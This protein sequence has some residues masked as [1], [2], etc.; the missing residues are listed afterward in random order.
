MKKKGSSIIATPVMISISVIAL[1]MLFTVIVNLIMPFSIYQKIDNIAIKYMF[2]V[3]KF[4][5]LTEEEKNNLL[6]DLDLE[7]IN[8]NYVTLEYP[9]KKEPYGNLVTLKI[10]Y[11]YNYSITNF[12]ISNKK[13][14][15]IISVTKN[16][17]SKIY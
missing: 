15:T 9:N 8:S 1:F 17:F 5:F 16:S 12:S 6:S 7:G 3:E 10:S 14:K 11:E 13:E 2:I 4:G